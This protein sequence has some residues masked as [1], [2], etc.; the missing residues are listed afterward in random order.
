MHASLNQAATKLATRTRNQWPD[1][2]VSWKV[3][4]GLQL[5]PPGYGGDHPIRAGWW[6]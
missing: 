2:P 1:R 5:P 3:L 4:R 6:A